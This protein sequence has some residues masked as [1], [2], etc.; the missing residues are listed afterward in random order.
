MYTQGA[1]LGDE[2]VHV[3]LTFDSAVQQLEK[4]CSKV[5]NGFHKM[6]RSVNLEQVKNYVISYSLLSFFF[7][8]FDF[9]HWW[10]L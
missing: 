5:S 4:A 3:P 7:F 9:A 6:S 8:F 10:H 2:V 1:Y